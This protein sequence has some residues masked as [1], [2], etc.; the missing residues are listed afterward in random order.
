M[1]SAEAHFNL[2]LTLDKMGEHEEAAAS[3]RKAAG[4]APK[5]PKI[6]DSPILKEHTKM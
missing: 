5:N 2:A 4:L 1:P 3:F 6:T